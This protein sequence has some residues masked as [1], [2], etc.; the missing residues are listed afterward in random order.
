MI[1]TEIKEQQ[2]EYSIREAYKSLR[3][4]LQ[5]CGND[6]KVI[7]ITSSVPGEGKSTVTLNLA[8]SLA[9]SGKKVMIVDSDMRRSVLLGRIAVNSN[10]KGLSYFLSNQSKLEEV[11]CSTNVEN[12]HIIFSG[13]VPPNP[14]ELLDSEVFREMLDTLRQTYDYILIDTP[15]PGSVIDSAIVAKISDGAIFVI[16][17]EAISYRFACNVKAQL[18]KSNC[19]I[20]GVV[21]NK[22]NILNRGYYSRNYEK[23][24]K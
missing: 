6:K 4:N 9:E 14:T 8:V 17:S 7:T 12:L 19:P 11:V 20:L 21:L 15:P 24:E 10:V 1:N 13:P 16:Q 5:F 2:R 22:V 3:T 18:E 23:Y